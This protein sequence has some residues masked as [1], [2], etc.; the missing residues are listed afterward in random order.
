MPP[1]HVPSP[2][3]LAIE[4]LVDACTPDGVVAIS[5]ALRSVRLPLCVGDA[6]GNGGE[7]GDVAGEDKTREQSG[8]ETDARSVDALECP[9]ASTGPAEAAIH[10]SGLY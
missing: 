9:R 7:D 3:A 5:R 6:D 4:L 10:S 2:L 8:P 1:A